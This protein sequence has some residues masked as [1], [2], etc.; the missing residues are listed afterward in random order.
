MAA[1]GSTF[2]QRQPPLFISIQK[3][4]DKYPDGQIFKEII[5]NADDAGATAVHFYLDSRRHGTDYLVEPKLATFQGPSL[6]AYNDAVFTDDDWQSIQDLQQSVKTKDPFKVGKFG[7][8]FNSVYHITDLPTIMSGSK[9]AYLEPHEEIWKKDTGQWYDIQQQADKLDTFAPFNN[10]NGYFTGSSCFQGTFFRFPLRSVSREKR[11]SSQVYTIDKLREILTALRDEARVILL[12]LRSVTVVEVHEISDGGDCTELLRVSSVFEGS[13]PQ[14]RSEFNQQ[15]RAAFQKFSYNIVHPIECTVRFKVKVEDFIDSV[16]SS[17]SEWLVASRVGSPSSEVHRMA[18]ALKALPWVGVALETTESTTIGG[19][20]FCVLPMPSEVSCHLPVHVNATFSLNDERRELKWAGGE[21][22]NDPSADWNSLI[23]QHLLPPCYAALLLGHAK[24]LLT[25]DAFYRAWPEVENLRFTPWKGIL[26]PLLKQ[27]LTEPVF[28]SHNRS[29][30]PY[31]NALFMPRDGQ[32]PHVVITALSDYGESIVTIPQNIW[33]AIGLCGLL[34]NNI[35]PQV[36]RIKLKQNDLV[37]INYA[38]N[39]KLDLLQYCLSDGAFRDIIGIRLLRLASN[40]FTVFKK[41]SVLVPVYLC[42]PGYP[43]RIIPG[44]KNRLVDITYGV[45]LYESLVGLAKKKVT[46]LAMLDT[47]G[48]AALLKESLPRAPVVTLPHDSVSMQW[49]KIFWGWAAGQ[50]TLHPFSGLLVV[51]GYDSVTENTCVVRLSLDCPAVFSENSIPADL[52]NVLGKLS[53][54]CCEK[55]RFPFLCTLSVFLMNQFTPDGVLDAIHSA[56]CYRSVVLSAQEAAS[57]R[58]FLYSYSGNPQ[59]VST[60]KDLAI[61]TTLSNSDKPLYSVSEAPSATIEPDNFPLSPRNLP[62]GLILFS[63]SEHQQLVLLHSLSVPQSTSLDFLVDSVFPRIG[64]SRNHVELMNE[65]F[66]N[67]HSILSNTNVQQKNKLK[68]GI[69]TL[70]FLPVAENK[71]VLHK[72]T[73]LYDPSAPLLRM[74]FKGQLVFPVEPFSSDKCLSVLKWCGLKT[75]VSQQELIDVVVEITASVGQGIGSVDEETYTRAQAVLECIAKL[76]KTELSQVV[77]VYSKRTIFS[78][79]MVGLSALKSWLPVK[80]APTEGYPD[81]LFWKGRGQFQHLVSYGESTIVCPNDALLELACGSQ[82]YF[83]NHSLPLD[84]C[85]LFPLDPNSLVKHVIA[86][87]SMVVSSS[88]HSPQELKAVTHAVYHTLNGRAQQTIHH[89]A[90]MPTECIYISRLNVF[91]SPSVVALQQNTSFRQNLEPFLYTLPDDLYPF[92]SLF[93]SLGVEERVSKQQIVR[94]LGKIKE[95]TP[96]TLGIGNKEAWEVVMTILNWLTGNGDHMVDVLDCDSLYVPVEDDSSDWPT[97]V[98]CEGVVY[99][100]NDFLRRYIGVSEGKSYK[101]VNKRISPQLAQLLR[102]KPLSEFLDIAEDAFE[103]AGQHEPLTVRLKNI[104]KDYKEGL[105]II[106]ELLQNADDAGATEV[107]ICYDARNHRVNPGS[108]LF[109]GMASCHGPALVVHNN[110]VF[111]QEDFKNVTKLAGATKEG[112]ALKIGKFG[113]GF[114]SVYHMTDVPS[115]ISSKYLYI[116]DPTLACLKDDIKNPAQPGKKVTHSTSIVINSQQLAPYQGLF[117]FQKGCKY[118]GTLF[119]FPFRT[120]PSDLSSN[121]YNSHTVKQIFEGIQKKSSELLLFLQSVKCIKVHEI[122][123]GQHSPEMQM[124]ISKTAHVSGPITIV[125]VSCSPGDTRY[126]LVATHTDTVLGQVA[127]ASVSCL[128]DVPSPYTPQ[129]IEGEVFCF[130]PL[131][132]KTG[133][134]VHISSNFAVTNNR[135]GLWTSDD[136]STNIREVRWNESLMKTVIPKAYFRMLASLKQMSLSS[137]LKEYLFYKL[138]PLGENLTIHNP[139]KLMIDALYQQIQ[140]SD[141]FFS[142]CANEWLPLSKGRFLS[143]GILSTNPLTIPECVRAVTA[144]LKMPIID[145]SLEYHVHIN[146]TPFMVTEEKFLRSFFGK[147]DCIEFN[148]RNE[149]LCLALQC[150]A[151]E[152]DRN[153]KRKAYLH[154]VL[155]ANA[156]I[157]CTP[158]G[159]RLRK[160]CEVVNPRAQ[161]AGLF[162]EEEGL[163]PIKHFHEKPLVS[164]AMEILGIVSSHI[165]MEMLKERARTVSLLYKDCRNKGLE[166]A[167]LILTCL[168]SHV[169]ENAKD[170]DEMCIIPFLPVLPRPKDYAFHW[171][172]DESK[173]LSGKKLTLKGETGYFWDKRRNIHIA[174]SQVAFTNECEPK[175]GGCGRVSYAARTILRIRDMPT[176]REVVEH[177]VNVISVFSSQSTQNESMVNVMDNTVR[178]IYSFLENALSKQKSAEM[179]KEGQN[180]SCKVDLSQLLT[181]PCIWTGRRLVR[182]ERVAMEWKSDTGPCLF[183]VPDKHHVHLWKELQIKPKFTSLDFISALKE[184]SEEHGSKTVSD[185]HK[186]VLADII[187]E[188]VDIDIPEKHPIIMLP[189][190][191][192]VMHDA[193]SLAFNDAQW[194]P[195]DKEMNY[196]NHKLVTRDLAQKLGVRMV[197]SKVLD[198]H[199]SKKPFKGHKFG[200]HEKLT[201][202]IQGILKDY[203]FDVTILKELL[204]NADDAKASKMYVILD[205]RTHKG[206]CLLSEKWQDLQGPALLVWNDSVFS[207]SDIEGIQKLGIGTKPSDADTIGQ[208][209]I[210]FNSVYHLTDC[211]SF[212]SAGNLCVFD[213]HCKFSPGASIEHPGGRFE[214]SKDFWSDFPDMKP[215]YLQCSVEGGSECREILGGSLFRFPLRHT[216]GLVEA[217]EIV[218]GNEES[219]SVFEG[220]L[221][222]SRMQKYL[223]KWAPQM[224]QSMFFLNHVTELKFFVISQYGG[225]HLRLEHHYRVSIDDLAAACR[226]EIHQ[227]LINFKVAQGAEPYVTKY[228]LTLIDGD[229]GKEMKEKWLIQQGVGDIYNT[230]QEWKYIARVKPRHGIAVPLEPATDPYTFRGRVFC[231]LPLPLDCNLPVHIHG[232]F[233]LHSNRRDL[234]TASERGDTDSKQQWN[235]ALLKAIASSYAQLLLTIKADY[236]IEGGVFNSKD[237]RKYYLTFPSWTAPRVKSKSD[238]ESPEVGATQRAAGISVVQ[239]QASTGPQEPATPEGNTSLKT[240]P[241]AKTPIPTPANEWRTLAEDVF[242]ALVA[243]NAPIIAV[244]H[245]ALETIEWCPPKNK[246]PASQVHFINKTCSIQKSVLERI[247]M[248][249]T[250][251]QFWVREHFK[252]VGCSIP[253]VSPTVSYQ[254]YSEFH[255]KVLP[256]YRSF[257]CPVQDTAF[258]SID[259]FK[260]FLKFILK[261]IPPKSQPETLEEPPSTSDTAA[262]VQ[263]VHYPPLLVTAEGFLR[264]CNQEEDT[265]IKSSFSDRF[266]KCL[267]Y[268]LHPDMSDLQVPNSDMSE[269]EVPNSFLMSSSKENEEVCLKVIDECLNSLLPNDLVNVPH[270]FCSKPINLVH[271]WECLSE[272]TFFNMFLGNIVKKWAILVSENGRL[273]SHFLEE[274]A[275]LPIVPVTTNQQEEGN[276]NKVDLKTCS[277]VSTVCARLH[278]PFLDIETVPPLAVEGIC[279]TLFDPAFMLRVIYN[280]HCESDITQLITADMANTLLSYFGNIH[281]RKEAESL[282]LLKKL[283]LFQTHL[284]QFTSLSGKTVYQWPY[285]MCTVGQDLWLGENDEIVFLDPSGALSKLKLYDEFQVYNIYPIQIYCKFVFKKFGCMNCNFR[286]KH[287][288]HIQ[289]NLFKDAKT[290]SNLKNS[291]KRYPSLRFIDDLRDLPCIGNDDSLRAIGEFYDHENPIFSAFEENFQFL[292]EYFTEGGNYLWWKIFFEELGFNVKIKPAKFLDLC[293]EMAEKKHT[294]STIKKSQVLFQHLFEKDTQEWLSDW[295][296]NLSVVEIPFVPAEECRGYTWIAKTP[297]EKHASGTCEIVTDEGPVY[298]TKLSG[299]CVYE[300]VKLVWS[301]KPVYRAPKHSMNPKDVLSRLRV[302]FRAEVSDVI[303][304]IITISENGRADQKLFDT[305]TAPVP[306]INDVG[307]IDVIAKCFEFLNKNAVEAD[308]EILKMT[309]CIPVPASGDDRKKIVLVKPSQALTTEHAKAF[310]PYLQRVPYELMASKQLLE[311]IGVKDSIQVSHIQLV[312]RTIHNQLNGAMIDPNARKTICLAISHLQ[313]LLLTSCGKELSPLYLAGGDNCLHHTSKLVYPDSYSYKDC[314]LPETTDFFVLHYPDPQKNQFDFANQFCPVLPKEVRPRPLSELCHQQILEK[315]GKCEDIEMAKCL[316]IALGLEQLPNVCISTF[317]KYAKHSIRLDNIKDLLSPFFQRV[318][319][320]TVED[321][322]VELAMKNSTSSVIGTA[323]VEFYLSTADRQNFCLYLD[324][325]V[326][327]MVEEHIHKTMVQELLGAINKIIATSTPGIVVPEVHEAFCLFLKAKTNEELHDACRIRGIEIEDADFVSALQPQLGQ[328]IPKEWHYMLDQNPDNIF[329][330]Q[331][332]VGYEITDGIFIFAQVLYVVP[333]DDLDVDQDSINPLLTRYMIA[334]PDKEMTV[335]ALDIYKFV[336]KR[337]NNLATAHTDEQIEEGVREEEKFT[338]AAEA[339]KHLCQQLKQIWKMD[340]PERSRA[341]RRLYLRWHPDKNL[342]NVELANEVFVFLKKQIERLEQGLDPEEKEEDEVDAESSSPQWRERYSSW[343]ETV[344][345]HSR[346][347]SRHE[348]YF[349]SRSNWG[350]VG[351]G[352]A[353]GSWPTPQPN[354]SEGRRWVLQAEYDFMAVEALYEKAVASNSKLFSHVCFMAHEVAEKA[355]KGGVYAVCGLSEEYLKDHKIDILSRMLRGERMDLAADLPSLTAPLERY[356]L[357]TRFPNRCPP[358]HVPSDLFTIADA[359]QAHEN[360]KNILTIVQSIIHTC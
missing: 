58:S 325:K 194:L 248:K 49:L 301:V 219:K 302:N 323:K 308:V 127:T 355:L 223:E 232:H 66:V 272:D 320:V 60:L 360:A 327:R 136:R 176:P 230:Q 234:W 35:N 303:D 216:D 99:T 89:R 296:F 334:L 242:R 93:K 95:G 129:S 208:Y 268:F 85:Q 356:Y 358:G 345:S 61:F 53:V 322:E 162:D 92:A 186:K 120:T 72:P 198:T 274:K 210:G 184:I 160:C 43:S 280:F 1:G 240:A 154:S 132:V 145:L 109:P 14:L 173:L 276:E 255:E 20:V 19:R 156:C 40:S 166:R 273:Y 263:P 181:L 119:R 187:S 123:D 337:N 193:S 172:G 59:R 134:P 271:L 125:K 84:T 137:Q 344:N 189:D 26:G 144:T 269:L 289:E 7:I 164:K 22:K 171:C 98:E 340:E 168:G 12:F 336:R 45:E 17:E 354:V 252:H 86:H 121:M 170:D 357:E 46:Q 266:P 62:A 191:K 287:L 199:R 313:L 182:C 318:Q 179:K 52:V 90:L 183:K 209:G 83:V 6:L 206:G 326:T 8:G 188:M 77:T 278:L 309:P 112:K 143:T 87:L 75:A 260:A 195:P 319:V 304:H 114:C 332:I 157:P 343:E 190:E 261:A 359:E 311:R 150:Y 76:S 245:S 228:Q 235:T 82:V 128:L 174:G 275:V 11:V 256:V 282:N 91:V 175:D 300:D 279:P 116:F 180:H 107:N 126:W 163:F 135:T 328:P 286:Y 113:I 47:S 94:I 229:G 178:L 285:D 353:G 218:C 149:V 68:C 197:R 29:W 312:L 251:T 292:P 270:T 51:P 71:S 153:T 32:V 55:S 140:Q 243:I 221:T 118:E 200:P 338:D 50:L 213:P 103:D 117:G 347:R 27:I 297:Q 37:Y 41:S 352:M 226:K 78:N 65:V 31:S 262:E 24:Q 56:N 333:P 15:L 317:K 259:N 310:F 122:N 21:R 233:I 305:Y 111:T 158:D 18:K 330:A 102:L 244:L 227:K 247:G 25:G 341:I 277:H 258:G 294:F 349:R 335:T 212:I 351:S 202:R 57:L 185:T 331:E 169:V 142:T 215:A 348:Q 246:D 220:V 139:W 34:V 10:L 267:Q 13:Q 250:T 205:Q 106:K 167:K 110:A 88:E 321:L 104:L 79:V 350:G 141:L 342:D 314:K 100:D 281:L 131:S 315:C 130:L 307:L 207:E 38:P 146:T 48:V 124:E 196:V 291:V 293:W 298:L 295:D 4:L 33:D 257:P 217:S 64:Y 346:Y 155:T 324:S 159:N 74:L 138:W 214:L 108:L 3:I 253:S 97:L 148:H 225:N 96:S 177:F 288:L 70:S 192:H 165:S 161:F 239:R 238:A 81:R 63:R 9:L 264:Y 30:V 44:C 151:T 224:K 36:V 329:H 28:W 283:P 231:F 73:T 67:I 147:I 42:S 133:L 54:K 69:K 241:F 306:A 201:T 39:Q 316:K 236:K 23:I 249:I 254:Y 105:T 80:L 237:V 299:A 101:L 222:A 5:Q 152:L 115:F 204:Q 211:P 290:Q 339:K 284:G 16:N 203:P 265:V 2:G